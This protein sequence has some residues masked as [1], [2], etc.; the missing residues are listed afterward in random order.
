MTGELTTR[1]EPATLEQIYELGRQ[2]A[3]HMDTGRWTIGDLAVLIKTHYGDEDIDTF[4]RQINVPTKRVYEYR[5]VA[6]FYEIQ[7]RAEFLEANPLITYTHFRTAM[8][9][10][11]IE[12]A[13]QFL[14]R[15]SQRAWTSDRA[16][17][18]MMRLTGRKKTA[19]PL[20]AA[21][22]FAVVDLNLARGL[23]FLHFDDDKILTKFAYLLR[24]N[25]PRL[26]LTVVQDVVENYDDPVSI[27]GMAAR[28]GSETRRFVADSTTPSDG[29]GV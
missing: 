19:V 3:Q 7:R 4:S 24:H 14:E 6:S 16:D 29:R 27:V 26:R 21:A 10:G 17:Y 13:Y 9:R 11:E 12:K 1:T 25:E 15:A 5:K 22:P 2:A 20:I 18:V 23:V 8:R 28:M